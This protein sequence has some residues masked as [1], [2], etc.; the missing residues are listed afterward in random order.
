MS[1]DD[2][3]LNPS[4]V[5]KGSHSPSSPVAQ[6]T[7]GQE[8][9]DSKV[10]DHSPSRAPDQEGEPGS[11]LEQ[12]RELGQELEREP[13]HDTLESSPVSIG[14]LLSQGHITYKRFAQYAHNICMT[15]DK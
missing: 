15:V 5:V 7:P 1:R 13:D 10:A 8:Q 11:E 9:V 14:Y 4:L 12:D 6:K 2:A 3:L